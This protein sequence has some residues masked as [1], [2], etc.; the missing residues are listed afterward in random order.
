MMDAQSYVPTRLKVCRI[1]KDMHSNTQKLRTIPGREAI[2]WTRAAV[3]ASAAISGPVLSCSVRSPTI[4]G[5]LQWQE[6]VGTN[7]VR[8]GKHRELRYLPKEIANLLH[9]FRGDDFSSRGLPL[10]PSCRS[11]LDVHAMLLLL[12]IGRLL[13]RLTVIIMC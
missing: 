3:W 10:L 1:Q 7:E 5:A 6:M 13:R 11:R 4:Y 12:D 9:E 2:T 8:F